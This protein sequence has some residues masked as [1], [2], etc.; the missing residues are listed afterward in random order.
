MLNFATD[1]LKEKSCILSCKVVKKFAK[2]GGIGEQLQGR[3]LLRKEQTENWVSQPLV[4][5]YAEYKVSSPTNLTFMSSVE[6]LPCLNNFK[7]AKQCLTLTIKL[8]IME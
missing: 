7:P 3:L 8:S 5:G 2:P 4:L 6:K 1:L